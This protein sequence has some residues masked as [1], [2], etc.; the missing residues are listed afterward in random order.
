VTA[1]DG[2]GSSDPTARSS[3][4]SVIVRVIDVNDNAPVISISTLSSYTDTPDHPQTGHKDLS[5]TASTTSQTAVISENT[6]VGTF[7]AHVSV[8]DDD[9]AGAGHVV[10]D[11]TS[12]DSAYFRLIPRHYHEYQASSWTNF[13]LS[14]HS[15]IY[16]KYHSIKV[17]C[18]KC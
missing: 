1:S 2:A 12:P 10:C 15:V 17:Q 18:V 5:V 8:S 14:F 11:V 3:D 13:Y 16:P 6:H 9:L 7:V 4:V